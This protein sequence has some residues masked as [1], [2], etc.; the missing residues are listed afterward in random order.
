MQSDSMSKNETHNRRTALRNMLAY[1]ATPIPYMAQTP[2]PPARAVSDGQGVAPQTFGAKGDG[3]TDDTAAVKAAVAATPDGG[4]LDLGFSKFAVTSSIGITE[5]RLTICAIGGGGLVEKSKITG[6]DG[7]GAMLYFSGS[8]CT[9]S[10][11]VGVNFYGIETAQSFVADPGDSNKDYC[12]VRFQQCQDV[13]S[14]NCRVSGKRVGLLLDRTLNALVDALVFNGIL[15]TNVGNSNYNNAVKVRGGNGNTIDRLAARECGSGVLSGVDASSEDPYRIIVRAAQ[16]EK[17]WDNGVYLSSAHDSIVAACTIKTSDGSGVKMRG[18]R[19]VCMACQIDD[20]LVGVGVSGAGASPD[21]YNSNGHGSGILAN[22]IENIRRDG[23]NIDQLSSYQCRNVLIEGNYL[24]TVCTEAIG[25][26]AI[27]GD[28]NFHLIRGNV[29]EDIRSE[30][31]IILAGL[32]GGPIEGLMIGE[33]QFMD[34]KG[35]AIRLQYATKSVIAGNRFGA[36]DGNGVDLRH[37]TDCEVIGNREMAKLDGYVVHAAE[38]DGNTGNQVMD[39]AGGR[40]LDVD[41][42]SNPIRSRPRVGTALPVPTSADRGQFFV[43]LGNSSTPDK[44]YVGVK[45]GSGAYEWTQIV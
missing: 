12:A 13:Q 3:L 4:L 16:I 27:R 11:V 40:G 45:L 10:S 29:F 2:I 38:A 35:D 23:I 32:P 1:L 7:E 34:I 30:F 24:R 26:G 14:L 18:S 19:N 42:V 37:C 39:N 20:C 31:A 21:T 6:A 15:P 17:A 33:N 44:M 9:G 36:V 8:A 5:K 28:G 41:E 43:L 25:Y 22:R